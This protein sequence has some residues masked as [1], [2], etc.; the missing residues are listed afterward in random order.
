MG[1]LGAGTEGGS[2]GNHEPYGSDE[3]ISGVS[4]RKFGAVLAF[5]FNFD[6]QLA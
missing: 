6:D 1:T 5:E 2:G 4:Q 3:M